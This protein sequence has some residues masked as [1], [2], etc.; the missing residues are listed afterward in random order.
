MKNSGI[1]R[2]TYA[3]INMSAVR[4]NLLKARKIIGSDR[5]LLFA[6]KADGYGH[7]AR[8]LSIIAQK[9]RLC[10]FLGVACVEEGVLL[11]EAGV[12]LPVLIL[13]SMYPFE[14]FVPALKNNLDISIASMAAAR[15]AILFAQNLGVKARCHV[16]LETGMNRTGARKPLAVEILR[17]LARSPNAKICG[18]YTHLSSPD[19][20]AGYTKLQLKY[21]RQTIDE[22]IQLGVPTGIRHAASSYAMKSFPQSLFNMARV[23]A[24][25]YGIIKGFKP[26]MS[27]KSAVIFI[28]DV[29]KGASIGYNRSY[30]C[31]RAMRVATIAI[32]YGDGYPRHLSNR[33]EFLIRGKRCRILGNVAMDMTMVDV[34]KVNGAAVGD[35]AVCMG[36]QGGENITAEELAKKAGTIS[37]EIVTRI[38]PRVP[39][40]YVNN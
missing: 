15:A 24:S 10:D 14:S 2:P 18:L 31:K 11:R 25:V 38:G 39:R 40:I 16:E 13:G 32:G 29:K 22:C 1:F 8:E 17:T 28:K 36:C 6:V 30:V 33:G 23:G 27:L 3:E 26:A 9:K 5:K 7:G 12:K 19:S 34:T 35:E 21:F 37:Y 20:D 4:S